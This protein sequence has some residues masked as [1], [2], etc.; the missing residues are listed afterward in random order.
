MARQIS[1]AQFQHRM[2]R[3]DKQLIKT[4]FIKLRALALMAESDAKKNATTYP[5]VRTGRLRSS[6]TG[7]V[8]T[9]NASPRMILRAGGNTRGAPVKYARFMEFGA[10]NRRLKPRF[11]MGRAMKKLEKS[12]VPKELQNLLRRALEES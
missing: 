7:L 12:N 5:K 4:L 1:L 2:R 11:F 8:D 6:I 3:A 9:K 10:P